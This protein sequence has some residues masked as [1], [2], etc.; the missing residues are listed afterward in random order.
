[1]KIPSFKLERYFAQYEFK[2]QH[3]LSPSDCESLALSELL[4]MADDESRSL[5]ENLRLSYT[6]SEGHPQLRQE[7]ARLYANIQPDQALAAAP[8]EGI[9]LLMQTLL[10]PGDQVI[11]LAPA[12][13]SLSEIA[14]AI[15]CEVIPWQV[16]LDASGWQI[17]LD[18]LKKNISARTRLVVINFPHNPTGYLPTLDEYNQ[19]ID[20]VRQNGVALFSDEM[21]R[22]LEFGNR[23]RLP[24]A[25]D[26]YEHA[27]SL[28]GLSKSYALPGLRIGWLVAQD[29]AILE[30]AL[31]LKDYTTIC[32]SA[33]SEI[34]GIIALQNST[35]IIDRNLAIIRANIA[36]AEAFF[37]RH[38]NLL[39][40]LAPRAGSTAFPRWHGPGSVEEFCQAALD[41][42]GVMIVPG[43]LFDDPGN[44]FR[45]GLGRVGFSE[46]L[47]SLEGLF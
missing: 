6:E 35:R 27:V 16:R 21:Y 22:G 7:I 36:A 19:L 40:W 26:V 44:H 29:R 4:E 42:L 39:D 15:G 46:A 47:D 18:W 14:R 3:L 37:A 8:E 25:A 33:P 32:L 38:S 34:L 5:W 13:Q 24:A 30:N 43:S 17:D 45:V 1:M 23:T 31:A 41:R 12:Y 20:I 9:F 2:V 10:I 28:S 11:A